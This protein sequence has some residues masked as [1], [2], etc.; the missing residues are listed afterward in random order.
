MLVYALMGV[1]ERDN[2]ALCVQGRYEQDNLHRYT[3]WRIVRQT[4]GESQSHR[5]PQKSGSYESEA[6]NGS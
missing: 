1:G 4:A 6:A 3:V 2:T 5:S